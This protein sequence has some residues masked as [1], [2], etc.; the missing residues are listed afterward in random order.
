VAHVHFVSPEGYEAVKPLEHD[1]L[2]P[3]T[4][5]PKGVNIPDV[6]PGRWSGLTDEDWTK[7][8][9]DFLGSKETDL[10]ALQEAYANKVYIKPALDAEW[11]NP[12]G[13]VKAAR[14][15]PPIKEG[16]PVREYSYA[17]EM[18]RFGITP[19]AEGEEAGTTGTRQLLDL[20]HGLSKSAGGKTLLDRGIFD[21]D[22]VS[23]AMDY[24]RYMLLKESNLRQAHAFLSTDGVILGKEGANMADSIGLKDAWKKAGLD[25]VG[26]KTWAEAKG[27]DADATK[28]FID[29]AR[30]RQ[31]AANVLGA[32]GAL[33]TAKVQN[34]LIKAWDT[35]RGAYSSALYAAWPGS[36]IRNLGSHTMKTLMQ[37]EAGL[38]DIANG[39]LDAAKYIKSGGTE[40]SKAIEDGI[41]AGILSGTQFGE[42]GE[43]AAIEH[44]GLQGIRKTGVLGQLWDA[45]KSYKPSQGFI[46][47]D[48]GKGMMQ[49]ENAVQRLGYFSTLIKKGKTVGE[50]SE[51]VKQVFDVGNLS[52]FEKDVAR[53]AFLFYS[54]PKQTVNYLMERL[55]ESPGGVAAQTIRAATEAAAQD[56]PGVYTPQFLREGQP[57]PAGG[58]PEAQRFLTTG[59]LPLGELNDLVFK[60]G[61]PDVGRTA[62]KLASRLNPLALAPLEIAS[63]R[64][65]QTGRKI[66]ELESPTKAITGTEMPFVDRA[67]HYSPLS[68]LEGTVFNATRGNVPAT[69]LNLSGLGHVA[70]YDTNQYKLRDARD[71]MENAM[72]ATPGA[73][74]WESAYMPKSTTATPQEQQRFKAYAKLQAALTKR[75]SEYSKAKAP[76]WPAFSGGQ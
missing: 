54:W 62:E 53:R 60:G 47:G 4:K 17:T 50:A 21:R 68:R 59:M 23:D 74:S 40:G 36:W 52:R 2:T 76:A 31:S 41:N 39:M 38:I 48:A 37:G 13:T 24:M 70:T 3:V 46:F 26:L 29:N 44:E 22:V 33:D 15:L 63:N 71:V 72:L 45:L 75:L 9:Q 27:M 64:Q 6:S 61:I 69:G 65:M 58:P 14:T 25:P 11:L 34:S 57:I 5:M 42:I 43:K 10:K 19:P 51:L 55:V 16:G 8:L 30:I 7:H 18:K 49:Y 28:E 67:A 12:D 56:Q 32:H 1:L 73:K 20:L 35:I 66:S